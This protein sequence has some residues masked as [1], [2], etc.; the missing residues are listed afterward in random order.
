MSDPINM[1]ADAVK[2]SALKKPVKKKKVTPKVVIVD[3]TKAFSN[4]FGERHMSREHIVTAFTPDS[5]DKSIV[6]LIPER[7]EDYTWQPELEEF[8]V[9]IERNEPILLTGPTGCGKTSM[10][11]NYCAFT[12]RPFVRMSMRGDIETSSILGMPQAREGETIW[13]DGPVTQAVK[14][15]GL[16]LFDE[17]D[18]TPP[19]IMYSIQWLLEENPRLLLTDKSDDLTEIMVK[20]HP[21][22]RIVF[23]GNTKGQG[24]MTG[25]FPGAQVQSMA[26]VDRCKTA[27]NF[28]YLSEQKEKAIVKGKVKAISNEALNKLMQLVG[29]IRV[30]YG[31]GTVSVGISP[32]TEVSIAEKWMYWNNPRK[33]FNLA[34]VNKLEESEKIIAMD[35]FDRVF[36]KEGD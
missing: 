15:G 36:G 18:F 12:N 27:L 13:I 11:E 35:A 5:W 20:A 14:L 9:A 7:Q 2:K 33:A 10:V 16:V 25:E 8:H 26:T 4:V 22:F 21:D 23:A 31:Q 28:S 24:D 30:C 6:S 1:V 29:A 34:Y 17:Y 3:G 32:R 19:E